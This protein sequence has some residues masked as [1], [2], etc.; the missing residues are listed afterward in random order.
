ME[1]REALNESE[2]Y[3]STQASSVVFILATIHIFL[4]PVAVFRHLG[5]EG[6]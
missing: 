2:I 5:V 6:A 4:A 3:E 1:E